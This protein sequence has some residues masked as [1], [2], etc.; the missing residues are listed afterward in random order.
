M[1]Q[2]RYALKFY[3]QNDLSHW[4][5]PDA[6]QPPANSSYAFERREAVTGLRERE[7]ESGKERVTRAEEQCM[8]RD[9][10]NVLT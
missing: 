2:I 3:L 6:T 9:A 5:K 8:K 10:Q 7:R 4:A 1:T